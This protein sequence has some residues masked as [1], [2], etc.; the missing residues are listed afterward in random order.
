MI[1]SLF[2]FLLTFIHRHILVRKKQGRFTI[3]LYV[4]MQKVMNILINSLKK[5]HQSRLIN[6]KSGISEGTQRKSAHAR[7]FL[8]LSSLHLSCSGD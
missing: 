1:L 8:S 7:L 6:D 3:T 2:L 4:D 5:F